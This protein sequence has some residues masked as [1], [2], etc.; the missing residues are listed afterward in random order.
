MDPE[1]VRV[2]LEWLEPTST[3]KV[4]SF[5]QIASFYQKFIKD[6]SGIS[7][8][9]TLCMKTKSTWQ[10]FE[11]LKQ[12]VTKSLVLALPDFEKVFQVDCD[13]SGITIGVVLSQEVQLIAFFSNKLDE[14]VSIVFV[15]SIFPSLVLH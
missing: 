4:R 10:A 15:P 13:T 5:H 1:K 6:F 2:I 12:K 8:T 11:E 9:L 7:A 3:I 14:S